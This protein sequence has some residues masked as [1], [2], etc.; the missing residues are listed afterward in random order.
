MKYFFSK[1]KFRPKKIFSEKKNIFS[2]K[3]KLKKK[4][5]FSEEPCKFSESH[6]S[7]ALKDQFWRSIF[8]KKIAK[9]ARPLLALLCQKSRSEQLFCAL[10]LSTK[11]AAKIAR[12][13]APVLLC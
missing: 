5:A 13:Q 6:Q 10:F 7:T 3:K 4:C 9:N 12:R 8:A 1:K 11:V 2:E